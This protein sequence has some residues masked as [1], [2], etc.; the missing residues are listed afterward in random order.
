MNNFAYVIHHKEG[1]SEERGL[2]FLKS[3]NCLDLFGLTFLSYDKYFFSS[4]NDF[5]KVEKEVG[6]KLSNSNS[7]AAIGLMLSSYSAW[8][9]FLESDYDYLVV[10]EDD[11]VITNYFVYSVNQLLSDINVSKPFILSLYCHPSSYP[12]YSEK[13]HGAE[14]L[15]VSKAYSIHA[16]PGYIVNKKAAALL[17]E[18]LKQNGIQF[19]LDN[20]L[21]GYFSWLI[22]VF[23]VRP[24]FKYK[25]IDVFFLDSS[26]LPDMNKTTI[27]NSEW[28]EVRGNNG[29]PNGLIP[30]SNSW[31]NKIKEM[32]L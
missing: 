3:K 7:A 12:N 21:F 29:F 27:H 19:P 4:A 23:S 30:Y 10:L 11:A 9:S 22:D 5:K 31:Y 18:D 17:V 16:S 1:V 28:I 14:S 32:V 20:H 13:I 26:G 6:I 15:A 2:L 24:D 8:N 25:P